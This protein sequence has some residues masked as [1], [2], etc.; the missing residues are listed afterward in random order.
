MDKESAH[1]YRIRE[2]GF[3]QEI[4]RFMRGFFIAGSF[5]LSLFCTGSFTNCLK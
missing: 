2:D 3:F 4:L 1:S 5:S